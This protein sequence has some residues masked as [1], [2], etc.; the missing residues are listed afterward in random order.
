MRAACGARLGAL[1]CSYSHEQWIRSGFVD[2]HLGLCK[3][4]EVRE[5]LCPAICGNNAKCYCL[6]V[7]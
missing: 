6:I 2:A 5:R 1:V 4:I 3:V 7:K